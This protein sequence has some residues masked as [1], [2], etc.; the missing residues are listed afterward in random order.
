MKNKEK[1]EDTLYC[2]RRLKAIHTNNI[3]HGS[4]NKQF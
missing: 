2:Q 1:K 3:R 4:E